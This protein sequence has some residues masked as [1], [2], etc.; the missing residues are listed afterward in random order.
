[1]TMWAKRQP[2]SPNGILRSFIGLRRLTT[3]PGIQGVPKF[4]VNMEMRDKSRESFTIFQ[5]M[6][7]RGKLNPGAELPFSL[8]EAVD[9]YKTMSE[10]RV[11]D[12]IMNAFQ[13]QGRISF[14]MRSF[15]EEA[16]GVGTGKGLDPADVVWPQYR[17]LGTFL[18]R[19]YSMEQATDQNMSRGS[20]E[21]KG[22]QM[23]SHYTDSKNNMQATTSPLGT[24]I[25][26]AVGAGYAFRVGGEKRVAAAFFGDGSASEGD[27]LVSLNFASTL[28][29]QML[30]LCRNN[31]FAISTPVEEQ[32]T[33]D[34]IAAR[35]V[36]FGIQT[37]RVDG[38]DLAA[39]VASTKAARDYSVENGKPVLLEYMSYRLGDHSTSDDSTRYRNVDE[40]QKKNEQGVEPLS[41]M[42]IFLENEGLWDE[43]QEKALTSQ[44]RQKVLATVRKVETKKFHS[45]D[46]LFDDV[47]ETLPR[48]L[49]MQKKE[50]Y[51]HIERNK[52]N[53]P[54]LETFESH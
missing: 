44:L 12:T 16:I 7:T 8:S 27:V 17:E 2:I 50:M 3:Y 20:D 19:G 4:S 49:E 42:R 24:S 13:R 47:Y 30:F 32:Y 33:G 26:H 5:L 31:G 11:Y 48:N 29:S 1:M 15:G 21:G 6:D 18:Q 37:I 22:R 36:A 45:L 34:G 54:S 38:N 23:P 41:R 14:Y 39:V 35:G 10:L 46:N 9:L 43:E 53:L 40:W 25:P 28:G 52:D 51:D